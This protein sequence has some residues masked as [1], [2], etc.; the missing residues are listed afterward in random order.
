MDSTYR[1]LDVATG[2]LL[3]EYI[4]ASSKD[5]R[6]EGNFD[7]SDAMVLGG[8]EEGSILIWD[9]VEAKILQRYLGHT[10]AVTSIEWNPKN[11]SFISAGID[12]TIR[13]WR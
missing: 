8:S 7:I 3:N 1:L 6:M 12:G 13:L 11:K 4:G 10:G 5:F 2:E 9:L